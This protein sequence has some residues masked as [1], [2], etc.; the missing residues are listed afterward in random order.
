LSQ[1]KPEGPAPGT[2]Q[3]A[4]ATA[5]LAKQFDAVADKALAAMKTRAEDL[6]I[7]GVAVV[8]WLEG[9]AASWSS[10]ML[11]VGNLKT[12]PSPNDPGVNLLAIA[13][14]K[15]A[16]MADTLKDSGSAVRPPLKGEYGW[17]GGLVKKGKTGYCIAAFSGGKSEDDVKVSQAGLDVL[18]TGL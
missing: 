12:P 14:S 7:K 10:K 9:D 18:A 17:Q 4:L 2:P 11:V 1:D 5:R 13:Y 15:A 16:E 8:V 6:K 3:A